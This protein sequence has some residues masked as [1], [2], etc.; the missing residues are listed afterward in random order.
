MEWGAAELFRATGERRYLDD[1]IRYARIAAD[2]SWMGKEQTKHYQYYPFMNLGNFRLYELV[3]RNTRKLLADYYR[4]ELERCARAAE[5]AR[6]RI[7]V[8][9]SG[10]SK[11]LVVE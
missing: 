10:L 1:A 4:A 2:E 8:R 11:Q 6:Y 7:E 3:V 5:K 9:L